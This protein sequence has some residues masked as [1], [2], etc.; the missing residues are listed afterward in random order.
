MATL[1]RSAKSGS[2]WGRRAYDIQ[3]VNEDLVTFFGTGQLPPPTVRTT[4]L[5][6]ESYPAAGLPNNEDRL[7]FLYMHEAMLHSPG[8]SAVDD[9]AAH[10]LKM[11]RYDQP[12]SLIRQRKDIPLYMCGSNVRAK[13]DVCV[14]DYSPENKGIFFLMQEDK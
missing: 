14:V 10:L 11:I 13:A 9:F 7:F 2:D 12:N 5:T 4:I 1:I 3:V 8:E 6:N